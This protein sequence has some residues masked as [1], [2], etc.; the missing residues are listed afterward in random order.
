MAV[1]VALPALSPDIVSIMGCALFVGGT[2]TV[3]TMAGFQEGREIGG[4][5]MIAALVSTAVILAV[6]R[7]C[8]ARRP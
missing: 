8:P 7:H 1:G 6:P 4:V 3:I 5:R 2:F